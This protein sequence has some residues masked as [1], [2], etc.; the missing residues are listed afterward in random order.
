MGKG[1]PNVDAMLEAVQFLQ[2]VP[3][4]RVAIFGTQAPRVRA[5][6]QVLKAVGDSDRFKFF[7]MEEDARAWLTEKA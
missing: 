1:L 3:T 6:H 5:M 7:R 2:E 4:H